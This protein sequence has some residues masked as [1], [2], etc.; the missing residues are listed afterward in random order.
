MVVPIEQ[1]H[2]KRTHFVD[3]PP[4]SASMKGA[5]TTHTTRLEFSV[6]V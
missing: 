1:N 2:L 3:L 4:C 5:V 6:V